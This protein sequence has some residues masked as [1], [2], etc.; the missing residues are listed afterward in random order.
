MS[1][2]FDCGKELE[3]VSR[4]SFLNSEQ[5]DAIKVGDYFADCPRSTEGKCFFRKG[6]KQYGLPVLKRRE[7]K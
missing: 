2:C 3:L 7:G 4:P 1:R 5:W 6:R